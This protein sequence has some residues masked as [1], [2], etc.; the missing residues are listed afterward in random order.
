MKVWIV[1]PFD[2]LPLEGNRPQRYW[3][4]ARAFARAGHDVTLWTSDFSHARK[5]PRRLEAHEARPPD[6]FRLVLVETPP[7]RH[8]IGLRRVIS[9][10]AFA[11]RWRARAEREDAPPDVLIASLPPLALGCA[12]MEFCCR[13]GARRPLFVVDVQDAWPETFERVAPR[14]MLAPLRR[15]AGR[16]YRAADAIVGVARRYVDLARAYGATAPMKVFR[17]GIERVDAGPQEESVAPHLRL[18]YA[19]NMG[20]S[21]DLATVIAGVRELADVTL[22]LAGSGPDEAHLR[23]LAAGCARIR[24]HGY[25]GAEELRR[26]LAG[27]DAAVIPMFDAACVGVSGKLADYAAAGLPVLNTLHGETEELLRDHGA[28]F[29][30]AAGDGVA[31][32]AAVERLRGAD[33][34]AL[35]RGVWRLAAEFDAEAVYGGYVAW[36]EERRRAVSAG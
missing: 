26:M 20:A 25:L 21:Y 27:C 19:G 8:N 31:F 17:L 18:A 12:A 30:Y 15:T 36:V 23:A 2:N 4:L 9:H 24:F 35:R 29:T 33:R 16:I 34:A 1:N 32:R 6:A 28:G 11:A 22:D 10:R 7:Y 3:L 14:W 5:A 13:L